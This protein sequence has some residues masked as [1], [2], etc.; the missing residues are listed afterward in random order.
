MQRPERD[1][2]GR[3]D[4][5]MRDVVM[6]FDVIEVHSLGNAVDLV[7]IFQIPVEMAVVDDPSKIALEVAVIDRI[8]PDQGDEEPPVRLGD[9]R[10]E[11]I[12]AIGEALLHPIERLEEPAHSPFVSGL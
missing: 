3:I 10:A 5:A 11:E 2:P 9:L 8:K 6:P 1:D 12:A 4:V 7:E